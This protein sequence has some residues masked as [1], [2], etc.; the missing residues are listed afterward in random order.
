MKQMFIIVGV[1]AITSLVMGNASDAAP[2][3]PGETYTIKIDAIGSN[4]QIVDLGLSTTAIASG[5]GK[6][7]FSFSGLP[8]RPSYNFLLSTIKDSAGS[9]VRR[10]IVPAP[11]A[12][13]T[14]NFGV[15]PMT[16]DQTEAMLRAMQSAGTDDPIMMLFGS[17]IIRSGGFTTD[18]II[19]LAEIGKRGIKGPKGDDTEGGFN[20]YLQGKIGTTKMA[21]FRS[22]IVSRLAD[23]TSL[24]K[25]GVDAIGTGKD[26]RAEAA[27][28]L[29]QILIEAAAEADFDVGYINAAMKAASDQIE[30]Y[31]G[32][33]PGMDETAVSAMDAVMASNYMKLSAERLRKRYA[34]ALTTLEASPEQVTRLNNAVTTLSNSLLAAFQAFEDIFGNEEVL[35]SKAEI[36][37]AQKASNTAMNAAF[38]QFMS[39][40]AST[41]AEIDD[42]VTAMAN[43]F[44][45]DV[46]VLNQMKDPNGD[47]NYTDGVFIFRDMNGNKKNWPITMV[48]PVTWVATN[49]PTTFNY[50]RDTLPIPKAMWINTRTN[51]EGQGLLALAA[52]FGLRED[53]E[54]IM[55]RKWTG[56][57]AASQDMTDAGYDTLS[58]SDKAVAV[59]YIGLGKLTLIPTE[60]T[61]SDDDSAGIALT[62]FEIIEDLSPYLTGFEGEGLEDLAL[63]RFGG[64][65][66]AIGPATVT[67]AQRQALIDT[68]T[69]PDFH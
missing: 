32:G 53:V 37:L 41:N 43:A 58:V 69:M 47:G 10:S 7:S 25:N 35:A 30:V 13:G 61:I 26:E 52:L 62:K 34:T 38:S 11:A 22:A 60:D 18:D 44:G 27:A 9:T 21:T 68:A 50:T 65:K 1:I 29:S 64:R 33:S 15:S 8:T 2:L 49:Y 54:I 16:E 48:V 3:T 46:A 19:H 28:L 59:A 57:A 31:L 63:T 67:E 6:V 39:D 17:V 66:E 20:Y 4:G 45:I 56:L 24:L 42:M 51:F 55:A 36:E 5:A 40:S 14:V 12:G 23:Y